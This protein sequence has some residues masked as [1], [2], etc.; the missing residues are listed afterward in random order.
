MKKTGALI[1]IL[2]LAI[3][4]LSIVAAEVNATCDDTIQNQDE[5]GIDCGGVCPACDTTLDSTT[6]NTDKITQAFTCLTNK[7]SGKCSSLTTEEISLTLLAAPSQLIIDECAPALKSKMKPDGSWDSKIRDTALA[8]LALDH[9]GQDTAKS[10]QWLLSQNKTPTDLIWFLEQDSEGAV[11]CTISYDGNDYKIKVNEEKKIN[12]NAGPCL[13]RAQSNFLLQISSNCLNKEFRVSCDKQFIAA[14]IFK[15]QNSPTLNPLPDTKAGSAFDIVTVK[16][17]SKCFGSS[18]CNYEDS[19]WATYALIQTGHDISPFIPYLIALSES[20][21]KYLPQAFIYLITNYQE[22]SADL[23]QN[24]ETGNY[25]DPSGSPYSKFYNTALA[26][27]ALR[28]SSTESSS[29]AD[30]LIFQ[31]ETDGCW[32][33]SNNEIIKD[34]AIVL[35]ALVGRSGSSSGSG[36]TY[37]NEANYFC[38]LESDCPKDEIKENYFCSGANTGNRVCCQNKHL[39][40]CAEYYGEFCQSGEFCSETEIEALDGD[41]CCPGTCETTPTLSA[42]E[43]QNNYCKTECPDTQE[44]VA[45]DCDGTDVCCRTKTTEEGGSLWWLWVLIVLIILVV[46]AIIFREKLKMFWYKIKT[47]GKGKQPPA[48]TTTGPGGPG[49]PPSPGFPPIKRMP[50]PVPMP[51]QSYSLRPPRKPIDNTF[52]KLKGMIGK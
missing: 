17:N 41:E 14:K 6:D 40:T 19:L 13:S 27:L 7:V 15:N 47:R 30:W 26:L 4:S 20:N 43:Q 29:S 36:V 50:G 1:I 51:G 39:K 24:K 31:Q 35:W 5:T 38:I 32:K 48:Q 3:L 33:N 28:T 22:Y 23:V 10:E 46:L 8:V 34:T 12:S 42:C 18:S 11:E 21:E 49:M 44:E 9:V 16:I 37:C 45:Y 25:W 2:A 52:D